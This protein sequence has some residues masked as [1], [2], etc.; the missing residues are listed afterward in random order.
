MGAV[1]LCFKVKEE[2]SEN[3]NFPQEP[4]PQSI[5]TIERLRKMKEKSNP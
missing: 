2:Y 5:Q 4:D 1:C 3:E